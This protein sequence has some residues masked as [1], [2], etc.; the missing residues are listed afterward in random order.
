MRKFVINGGRPLKG[1]VN[2]SG[3][4]NAAVAV[5][6]AAMLSDGVCV[7]ENVPYIDD[8]LVWSELLEYMGA[9]ISFTRSGSFTID[10]TELKN[11]IP[12]ET[13]VSKMRASSYLLGVLLGRFGCAQVPPPGGCYIGAR[14]IDQHIKGFRALGA[15]VEEGNL[16]VMK[17]ENLHGAEVHLEASV[18]A[19]I[20]IMLAASKANGTTTIFNC[21]QFQCGW[22]K[23]L[24]QHGC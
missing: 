17:A 11:N 18:G 20:N 22:C 7:I 2:I 9:K 6:A 4:K 13:L 12:P 21:A 15:S 1:E 3:A 5:L 8:V 24:K 23:L 14:P 10:A 16:V 19:T